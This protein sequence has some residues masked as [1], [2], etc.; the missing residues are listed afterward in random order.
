MRQTNESLLIQI[1]AIARD[2]LDVQE[3]VWK[4]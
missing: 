2:D 3:S 4:I 1:K